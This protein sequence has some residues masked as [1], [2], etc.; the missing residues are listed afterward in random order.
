MLFC[1]SV[2]RAA[3]R[4]VFMKLRNQASQTSSFLPCC[5]VSRSAPWPFSR[6][7]HSNFYDLHIR[8]PLTQC[9]STASVWARFLTSSCACKSSNVSTTF[10]TTATMIVHESLCRPASLLPSGPVS[11]QLS[12]HLPLL[13]CQLVHRMETSP[14]SPRL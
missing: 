5:L 1:E 13:N 14:V 7:L 3:P 6:P 9:V 11:S 12:N 4:P 10:T 2:C 8:K